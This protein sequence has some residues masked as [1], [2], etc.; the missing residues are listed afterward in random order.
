MQIYFSWGID[1]GE[2]WTVDLEGKV[3][4]QYNGE[5]IINVREVVTFGDGRSI[6]VP[7]EVLAISYFFLSLVVILVFAL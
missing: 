1:Q 6:Q 2:V 4:L 7:Y 3:K 5:M